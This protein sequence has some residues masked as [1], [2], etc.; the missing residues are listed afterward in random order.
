MREQTLNILRDA[1][2]GDGFL[3][4]ITENVPEFAQERS[5]TA[6]AE[7]VGEYGHTP[8]DIGASPED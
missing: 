3:I 4:G 2:P 6:I 5:L 8:I 7:T 1:A